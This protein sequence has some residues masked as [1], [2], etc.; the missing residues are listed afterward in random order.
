MSE[1]KFWSK[2]RKKFWM[3]GALL[4]LLVAAAVAGIYFNASKPDGVPREANK[5]ELSGYLS[6]EHK[7]AFRDGTRL[8]QKFPVTDVEKLGDSIRDWTGNRM[9]FQDLFPG[10]GVKFLGAGQSSVPGAGQS[11]HLRLQS[12]KGSENLSLFVKQYRQLPPLEEGAAYSLPGRS[13]G[14]DA[15]PI[16]IWKHGGTVYYLVAGTKTGIECLRQALG[17][18]EPKKTY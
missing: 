6:D 1:A 3:I 7:A 15:P 4:I 5:G 12:D 8:E 17:A 18:P 16:T 2:E 13:L 14:A 11:A 9:A 10:G